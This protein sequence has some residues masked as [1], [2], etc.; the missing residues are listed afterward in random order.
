VYLRDETALEALASA[1]GG[2]LLQPVFSLCPRCFLPPRPPID[3]M[4]GLWEGPPLG[5]WEWDIV[6]A[7][8][9][10]REAGGVATDLAG[11][12]LRYNQPV[13]R[14]DSGLIVA[15]DPGLHRG[16]VAALRRYRDRPVDAPAPPS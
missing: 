1:L 10:V 8:L 4:I 11:T 16:L 14:F 2:R 6:P 5:A 3:A 7:D 13:P 9:I 15:A 12:P